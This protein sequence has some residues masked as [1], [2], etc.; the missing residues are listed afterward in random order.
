MVYY[1]R[2]LKTPRFQ[3]QKQSAYISALIC[4]S[5]DLGDDF[6]AEE[7]DLTASWVQHSSHKVRAQTTFRWQAGSRQLAVSLGPFSLSAVAAETAVLKIQL[8][9]VER[10]T[11]EEGSIPL[12]I[13]ANSAPFGP[14]WEPAEPLIRRDL[15]IPGHLRPLSIWEETGNSIARHI[16]DAA[17]AAVVFL[18]RV[19]SGSETTMSGLTK[20]LAP[21]TASLRVVELGAGCGIVGIALATMHKNCEVILTDLPEVSEI[22][23]RNIKEAS[24]QHTSTSVTFQTLDWDEPTPALVGETTD[25]ILVSDCTYNA[26]SLPALVSVLGRFAQESPGLLILV[27]LKRR[28]ESEAVFFDLMRTAGFQSSHAAVNLPAQWDQMDQIE[29]YCYQKA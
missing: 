12:V 2:F 6:L 27:S 16:W 5:T 29:M 11:L 24:A 23:S 20:L 25:L 4:I 17:L 9:D 10:D 18:D 19:V 26:D 22:V 1:I 3:Q 21:G 8:A 13:S 15:C 28:H 7:V 14:Q